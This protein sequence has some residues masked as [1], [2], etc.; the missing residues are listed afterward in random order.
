MR[1]ECN[2][3]GE[4]SVDVVTPQGYVP[5]SNSNI[6]NLNGINMNYIYIG[7]GVLLIIII[8]FLLF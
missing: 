8:L 3:G 1:S 5:N 6:Q 7:G 2:V 4:S